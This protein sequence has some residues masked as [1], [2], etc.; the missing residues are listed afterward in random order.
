MRIYWDPIENVPLLSRACS[1][2]EPLVVTLSKASDPRPAMGWDLR[3]LR[4]TLDA[5]FG[6]GTYGEL[7]INEEVVLLGR[8]PYLDTAYEVISDGVVL[9][10]LFFDLLE[11]RW[12]FKPGPPSIA[13]IGHRI[14]KLEVEGRR[15]DVIKEA[16]PED[17]K[18][19]LLRNGIA[20]RIGDK[21]VVIKEF[22]F[23][24]EPIDIKTSWK[25]VISFNEPYVLSKEFESI[26][27]LWRLPKGR[28]I[29]LSFSGGKD[30]SAL[31][32]VVRRSDLDFLVYFNDTGLELP[33]TLSF[34]ER[35]GCD[36]VGSAG[37][38][39]WRNLTHFGPPAR[40]YRWCC[41]ALKLA[42]TYRSLKGLKPA[43]TLVGQR[44]YE[45]SARMRSPYL[46]ENN[47]LPGILTAAPIND[48]SNL[49][50]WLYISVRKVEVNPLYFEGFERLGCYVCPASRISDFEKLKRRYYYLWEKWEGFLRDYA[51]GRGYGECWIKYGIWRWVNPPERMRKLCEF[52][53][54]ASLRISLD[55]RYVYVKGISGGKLAKLS[56]TL[57]RSEVLGIDLSPS[58]EL[59]VSFRGDPV[60]VIRL[61]ARA[62]LCSSCGICSDY[63]ES[64]AI[65]FDH[66]VEV[67][68]E[69]CSGCGKCNEVCPVSTY[70]PKLIEVRNR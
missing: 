45:S 31:L 62:E 53:K 27:M 68:G 10:H 33:E 42:P 18:F 12:Y 55:D 24:R 9:G 6:S 4:D 38:S 2:A 61:I 56:R 50:T 69:L 57:R 13:R 46:W 22:K 43:L 39:F 28:E 52:D 35:V 47:W 29:V 41:K 44:K 19:L 59:R 49:Q 7:V 66:G 60:D 5:Q 34:V 64:N 16:R 17:H 15:G 67:I 23:S 30:S 65:K 25:R 21:Y 63:C 3:L 36:I 1:D 54:R 70:A 20:E 51:S 26:R 14:E 37:N 58:G 48:W 8:A 32:E 40:D 11:F